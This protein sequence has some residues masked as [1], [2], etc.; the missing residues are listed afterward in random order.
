MGFPSEALDELGVVP[1]VAEKLDGHMPVENALP[2]LP[3][4][5]GATASYVL[6]EIE[7]RQLCSKLVVLQRT[8]R[9]TVFVIL[10]ATESFVVDAQKKTT[11]TQA[12][13][14]TFSIIAIITPET[15]ISYR[16]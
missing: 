15:P 5:A 9:D 10:P 8:F 2:C 12:T 14:H 7:V 4:H 3:D 11:R 16:W 1:D 13:R 6:F